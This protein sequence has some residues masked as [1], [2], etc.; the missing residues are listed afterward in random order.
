MRIKST[1]LALG[2]LAASAMPAFATNSVINFDDISVTANGNGG[3]GSPTVGATYGSIASEVTLGWGTTAIQGASGA[4][5]KIWDSNVL[6]QAANEWNTTSPFARTTTDGTGDSNHGYGAYT[7]SGSARDTITITFTAAAGWTVTLNSFKLGTFGGTNA[8]VL[9][10]DTAANLGTALSVSAS[11]GTGSFTPVSNQSYATGSTTYSPA[12][13]SAIGGVLTLT[14]SASNSVAI[15]DIN[16]TTTF[17]PEP[18]SM[19]LL[20]IGGFG[21][22]G[23]RR[24][25]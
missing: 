22:M 23:R 24:R 20:A 18:A 19:G 11:G 10:V 4:N 2:V 14:Y 16:F 21:L 5:F 3:G 1:V 9:G 25:A 13:T 8:G 15:D 17:V 6:T 12:V 7:G